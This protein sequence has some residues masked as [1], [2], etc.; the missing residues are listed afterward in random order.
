MSLLA[1][2][3][4]CSDKLLDDDDDEGPLPNPLLLLPGT[5]GA[6]DEDDGRD[7]VAVKSCS[8][9]TSIW[10]RHTGH[11]WSWASAAEFK[12]LS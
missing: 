3:L 7:G 9:F 4:R 11:S 2:P 10:V 12:V 6:A 5:A 1:K 8:F